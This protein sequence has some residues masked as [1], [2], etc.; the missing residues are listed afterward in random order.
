MN[1]DNYNSFSTHDNPY[2]HP[3]L[4]SDPANGSV[5]KSADRTIKVAIG[6]LVVVI[7]AAIGAGVWLL[8]ADHGKGNDIAPS[9]ET[10]QQTDQGSNNDGGNWSE[11]GNGGSDD[12][13]PVLGDDESD[14]DQADA[15][16]DTSDDK[17]SK[18]DADDGDQADSSDTN[19]E[20]DHVHDYVARYK[21]V[22][23]KAVTHKKHHPATYKK[24]TTYHTVCNTCGEV[25]DGKAESHVKKTG[26][27]GYTK[28][29]PVTKYVVDKKAYDEVVVDKKAYDENKLVG[30][31]CVHCGKK[32]SVKEMKKIQA[33]AKKKAKESKK[34]DGSES[35]DSKTKSD[36]SSAAT[37]EA[38]PAKVV[39]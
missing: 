32:V 11:S 30:Y 4:E 21:T 22:H 27:S 36:S 8:G 37:L 38:A 7:V 3:A 31:K 13:V 26:H 1:E 25:I 33:D 17:S 34:D 16:A 20:A 18:D 9:E 19:D 12:G 39:K 35:K 23:H 14:T 10:T 15:P 28:D 24:E 5:D 29:M 2:A 6:I